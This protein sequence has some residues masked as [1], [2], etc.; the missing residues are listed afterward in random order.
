M[1]DE[2][3]I[4][5]LGAR[6]EA[7]HV[8]EGDD[9]NVETVAEAHEAGRLARGVDVEHAGQRHRLVG[10]EADRGA[11]DAAKAANDVSAEIRADLEEVAF[12]GDLHDQFLHVIGRVRVWRDQRVEAVLDPLH[13]VVHGADGRLFAV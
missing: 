11:L 8:D 4:F 9:R 12:I 7:R 1:L 10:D 13:F 5:L 6:H 2:A 3:A